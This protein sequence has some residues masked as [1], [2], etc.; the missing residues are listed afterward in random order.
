MRKA[1]AIIIREDKLLTVRSRRGSVFISPGGK[2]LEGES[3]AQCLS[4]ELCE[5]LGVEV[6]TVRH[7]KDYHE[8][9]VFDKAP[10]T[11]EAYLIEYEGTPTPQS[12]ILE[13]RWASAREIMADEDEFAS[14]LR[15]MVP[16]LRIAG[17]LR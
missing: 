17:Y 3:P 13:I 12:E 10:L 14:G 8:Y 5:E 2:Y 7:F 16:D 6:R 11:L 4:R 15:K 1:A 9:A